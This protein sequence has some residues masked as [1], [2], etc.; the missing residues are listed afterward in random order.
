MKKLNL[1]QIEKCLETIGATEENIIIAKAMIQKV[2]SLKKDRSGF[3][4]VSDYCRNNNVGKENKNEE[5][6]KRVKRKE[7]EF[8]K[9][10]RVT[11]VKVLH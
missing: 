4:T 7:I 3:Y 1:E 2:F 9:S 11:L 10:G 6:A 5:L 8:V